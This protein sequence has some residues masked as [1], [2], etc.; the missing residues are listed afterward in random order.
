MRGIRIKDYDD[1]EGYERRDK[2]RIAEAMRRC[3][4]MCS[5][6]EAGILWRRYS[7][8]LAAEWI[9][10]PDTDVEI[11]GCIERY[12]EVEEMEYD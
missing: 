4:Y 6:M 2:Q 10:L 8:D 5:P 7:N 12:F 3:G 1:G 9:N 11:F